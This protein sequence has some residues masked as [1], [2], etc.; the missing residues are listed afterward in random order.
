MRSSALRATRGGNNGDDDAAAGE[1]NSITGGATAEQQ[2]KAAR[3]CADNAD[4]EKEKGVRR[5]RKELSAMDLV[6]D[7]NDAV[8]Q[9]LAMPLPLK[10]HLLDEWKL[11]AAEQGA[12]ACVRMR[13][14][15]HCC[16]SEGYVYF[17]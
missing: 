8:A 15:V 4:E 1:N 9:R 17:L 7:D 10:K 5:R 13:V 2:A 3:F 16:A 12:C 6:D 11:A 14:R